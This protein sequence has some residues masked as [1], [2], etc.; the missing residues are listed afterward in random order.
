MTT[1][2]KPA[3]YEAKSEESEADTDIESLPISEIWKKRFRWLRKAGGPSMKN[4]KDMPIS[5]RI[6]GST[7]NILAFLFGPFYY[8]AKGMWRKGVA[9][10]VVCVVVVVLL[11]IVLTLSGFA[12]VGKALGYGVSAVFA[13][14]ANIDYYKKMV[15]GENG[16]W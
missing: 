3:Q 5:E 15:L 2:A 9:L 13:V 4:I 7:F 16:W 6:R 10:F 1:S 14:R 12:K 11:D 8:I